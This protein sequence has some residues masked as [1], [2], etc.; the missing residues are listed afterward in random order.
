M[1]DFLPTIREI[2]SGLVLAGLS[3]TGS[4][5]WN[6]YIRRINIR[7][8]PS[9]ATYGLI[10][11]AFLSITILA[12][13]YYQLHKPLKKHINEVFDHQTVVLDGNSYQ[14]CVFNNS[15]LV[16]EGVRRFELS[17]PVLSNTQ[18]KLDKRANIGLSILL[19]MKEDKAM[20]PNVMNFFESL[21]Y[22]KI[23][24]SLPGVTIEDL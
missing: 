2:I 8:L 23:N 4:Y 16:I 18:F 12:F 10:I 3:W 22:A 15:L 1:E 20:E 21:K 14:N 9:W 11:Y 19:M 5:I 13:Q 6:K 24:D 17:S 7:Q